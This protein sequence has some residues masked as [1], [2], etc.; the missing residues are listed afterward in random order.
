[1]SVTIAIP[2]KGRLKSQVL[3]F[4]ASKGF[5]IVE[6]KRRE[7]HT[8]IHGHPHFKIVFLHPKDI[9]LLLHEGAVD[10]GFTGLDLIAET[11]AEVQTVFSLNSSKVSLCILAPFNSSISQPYQLQNKTV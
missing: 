6:P 7:M 11:K 1:M 9:A 4:L 5:C 8:T 2:S 10:I 3:Q